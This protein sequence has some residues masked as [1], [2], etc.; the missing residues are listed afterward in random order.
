MEGWNVNVREDE[1]LDRKKIKRLALEYDF[2]TVGDLFRHLVG[3]VISGEITLS[4]DTAKYARMDN[5]VQHE[6]KRSA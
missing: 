5:G 2:P 4:H 6:R 3:R 1:A